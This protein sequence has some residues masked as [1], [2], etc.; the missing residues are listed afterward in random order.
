MYFVYV[1]YCIFCN[2]RF[3]YFCI[4]FVMCLMY[5]VVFYLL[6]VFNKVLVFNSG[7]NN[8]G[9]LM[10]VLEIVVMNIYGL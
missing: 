5:I 10:L 1:G 6:I 9:N 3:M 2:V 4:G 7:N 8:F